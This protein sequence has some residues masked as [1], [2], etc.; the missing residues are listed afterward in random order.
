M[1]FKDMEPAYQVEIKPSTHKFL[2]VTL[3]YHLSNNGH[4]WPSVATL[5]HKT[6]LDRKTV[7]SGLKALESAGFIVDTGSRKGQTQ[8]VKV[9]SLSIPSGT[10]IGTATCEESGT[11]FPPKQSQFSHQAV[12]IFRGSGTDIGTQNNQGNS[13]EQ[14]LNLKA[15]DEQEGGWNPGYPEPIPV[16]TPRRD[17]QPFQTQS[18]AQE[19]NQR[20]AKVFGWIYNAI[21]GQEIQSSPAPGTIK[22]YGEAL[23]WFIS[24]S[25][26]AEQICIAAA[27]AKAKWRN[28]DNLS[29]AINPKSLA[30]NW[31]SL[32]TPQRIPAAPTIKPDEAAAISDSIRAHQEA[33]ARARQMR[34]GIK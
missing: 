31:H 11:D 28:I 24:E 7:L 6:G 12:P 4:A 9:Y 32:Y 33:A 5:I 10:D 27:A 2:F 1:G 23:D 25:I 34:F 18:Q 20:R 21:H 29:V 8:G 14:A 16:S 15:N 13:I 3:A 17:R 30:N 22:K 19:Q 26:T